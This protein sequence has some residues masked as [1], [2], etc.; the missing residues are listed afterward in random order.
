MNDTFSFSRFGM[1]LK[2]DLMENRKRYLGVFFIM[3]AAFLVFQFSEIKD[4]AELG[5]ILAYKSETGLLHEY[6]KA[7][8]ISRFVEG[9]LPFIYG[10]L[11]L[12][13]MC[14]AADMSGV[15]LRSKATS[16]NY[17]MMPAS[18]LEKFLSRAF[19]NTVVVIAMTF[20]ALLCA[21]LVRMLSLSLLKAEM[22]W[23][24]TVPRALVAW[25]EPLKEIYIGGAS[26][27]EIINNE[28]VR[29]HWEMGLAIMAVSF[30]VILSLWGHSLFILSGCIWRKRA[31]VK[32]FFL[33]FMFI[34]FCIWLFSE[35]APMSWWEQSVVPWLESNCKTDRDFNRLIF[36][37]GIPLFLGFI[38]L[39]WW[40]SFRIFACK[41]V[42]ERTHLFGGKHPHHLFKKAHS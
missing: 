32:M 30:V 10:V 3:F 23:G 38:A 24:L 7:D 25:I 6:E 40:L 17:L 31:L 13:L 41:Q 1:V 36:S 8:Y 21:D 26:G 20:V 5:R 2:R 4:V 18:N 35:I 39:N 42:V 27:Y 19:I 14:A 29:P 37:I 16:T 15:P 9:C 34:A 11:S 22:T 12:A 28:I 33:S